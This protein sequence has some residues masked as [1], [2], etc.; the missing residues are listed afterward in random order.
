M[1]R[2]CH[3]LSNVM[4]VSVLTHQG[5]LTV[6][7]PASEA[8]SEIRDWH[9]FTLRACDAYKA[10]IFEMHVPP[11][12]KVMI[13]SSE[14][15]T[16]ANRSFTGIG[17][18]LTK[19]S[20]WN[21][22]PGVLSCANSCYA[23]CPWPSGFAQDSTR[24][25]SH[26]WGDKFPET[27]GW[28]RNSR[29]GIFTRMGSRH[30]IYYMYTWTDVYLA[31]SLSAVLTSSLL[32]ARAGPWK[33]RFPGGLGIDWARRPLR[34]F[35]RRGLAL[36]QKGGWYNYRPSSSSN[37]SIRAFRAYPLVEIRQTILY[38][39]IRGSSISVSSTLPPSLSFQ[40]ASRQVPGRNHHRGGL[41]RL[42]GLLHL[43]ADCEEGH[44]IMMM[45]IIIIISSSSS[46][47]CVYIYIERERERERYTYDIFDIPHLGN[48]FQITGTGTWKHLESTIKHMFRIVF[49]HSYIVI[50]EI[51]FLG[52]GLGW[53]ENCSF[54]E[55]WHLIRQ[56]PDS[57]L[58]CA[59]SPRD[60]RLSSRIETFVQKS[61]QTSAY[62][63]WSSIVHLDSTCTCH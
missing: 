8:W 21:S 51:C 57:S 41:A 58:P 48:D 14:G 36:F 19:G 50:F 2:Y 12:R 31:F 35:S 61:Q 49:L 34:G 28:P 1:Q 16:Q 26:F 32:W 30:R 53:S 39:A 10:C 54:W 56:Q 38:R 47:I 9:A 18:H 11:I 23:D 63:L 43:L 46:D 22:R 29:P 20:P 3:V 52:W 15:S 59:G 55:L 17:L 42:D 40:C 27:E 4:R 24:A 44:I 6:D 62:Y 45:M 60:V 5:L 7:V 33:P 37:F 13:G 25:D